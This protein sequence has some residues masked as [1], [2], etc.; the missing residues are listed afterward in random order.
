MLDRDVGQRRNPQREA[1]LVV[2]REIHKHIEN[3]IDGVP[4]P[5]ET[6]SGAFAMQALP[7]LATFPKAVRREVRLL[8][9]LGDFGL[10]CTADVLIDETH[11]ITDW[12]SSS[13][14]A[15]YALKP[16]EL[17]EDVQA[18]S[19][20]F[21]VVAHY[22]WPEVNLKWVYLP[23]R[24]GKTSRVV[25]ER[26]TLDDVAARVPSLV[27]KS[28][29]RLQILKEPHP[30]VTA[31]F[32]ECMKY[33]GCDHLAYCPAKNTVHGA[34]R[35][36]GEIKMTFDAS[37]IERV[38]AMTQASAAA[39]P[40][41]APASAA[42]LAPL[43][44]AQTAAGGF[45]LQ[46]LLTKAGVT[47]AS[48]VAAPAAA[49]AAPPPQAAPAA[50][51]MA[52]LIAQM[53]AMNAQATNNAQAAAPPPAVQQAAP[54]AQAQQTIAP[55]TRKIPV[56]YIDCMPLDGKPRTD[57]GE[58]MREVTTLVQRDA[59]L[60][61]YALAEYGKGAAL[62]AMAVNDI[63]GRFAG[64]EVFCIRQPQQMVDALRAHASAVVVGCK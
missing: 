54:Q 13:N 38:R 53:Q 43:A 25:R 3:A 15:K 40:A 18:I 24:A 16:A 55:L 8:T 63:M 1:R 33:T 19:I 32:S 10:D 31:A 23:T 51:P 47:M 21:S 2:G 27:A 30:E 50:D 4:I 26:L 52:A 11:T 60:A 29:R 36:D 5:S 46:A 20:A 9:D 49:P 48:P 59:S 58:L 7:T 42:A 61:H 28:R 44:P 6:E 62:V 37:I 64:G 34:L 14:P 56:L 12:K 35:H 17:R 45:D 39:P 57:A 41:G 22:R